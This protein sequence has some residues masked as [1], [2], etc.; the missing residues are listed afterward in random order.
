M[1]PISLMLSNVVDAVTSRA[2]RAGTN[3]DYPTL[4]YPL[5]YL[6]SRQYLSDFA[7]NL[8]LIQLLLNVLVLFSGFKHFL[9]WARQPSQNL[10]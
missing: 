1:R 3:S 6:T 10:L 4:L 7:F 2:W 5:D 8:F 9:Q